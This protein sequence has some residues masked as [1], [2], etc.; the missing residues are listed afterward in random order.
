MQSVY[1]L[2]M[3]VAFLAFAG[4]CGMASGPSSPSSSCPHG[5]YGE[6]CTSVC[7]QSGMG[8]NCFPDC[9][10]S[11]RSAGLGDATTCCK[12]TFR[13]YCDSMCADL[14]NSTQGDTPKADCMEECT[15]TASAAGLSLDMCYLPFA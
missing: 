7:S 14:E 11:V 8:E 1:A 15:L 10:E 6:T 4:C 9:T 5:T 13:Q 12:I 2:I 3:L